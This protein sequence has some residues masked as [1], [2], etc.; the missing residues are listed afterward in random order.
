MGGVA[1]TV[2][3]PVLP[4]ATVVLVAWAWPAGLAATVQ[5]SGPTA[6]IVNVISA[7]VS[8]CSVRLYVKV[9]VE[10]PLRDAKS[11]VSVT[12][13]A[14]ASAT[15]I[16]IGRTSVWPPPVAVTV[17]VLLEAG[18][19]VGIS[20]SRVMV[21]GALGSTKA[22]SIVRPPPRNRAVQPSGTPPVLRS[23]RSAVGTVSVRLNDAV[24]PGSA[25]TAGKGVVT[26]RPP[27]AVA[28]GASGPAMVPMR[29][30]SRAALAAGR[31]RR[32]V[33]E[34]RYDTCISALYER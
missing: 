24:E 11:A 17:M 3:E 19:P 30:R 23:T 20:T 12:S 29:P 18:A 7:E 13:P 28:A 1:V 34:T 16:E 6:S 14:A 21:G 26:E 32:V 15:R 10:G 27:A 9:V 8:L 4:A 33:P 22:P 25:T 31:S 2:I 5:P